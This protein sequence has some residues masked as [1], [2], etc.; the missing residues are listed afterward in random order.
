MSDRFF[1]DTNI[2][3]YVFDANAIAKAEISDR[4]IRRGIG[5]GKGLV[6]Y[7]VVQEFFN[8]AFKKF[9]V[10]MSEADAR[11]Y[12]TTTLRPMLAVF[13]SPALLLRAL[14]IREKHMIAWYDSLILAAAIEGECKT[15]YTEDFRHGWQIDG[16]KIQN[17]FR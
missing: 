12:F 3:A 6:S 9:P 1:L 10:P 2:F 7:Q 14:G 13:F 11:I 4:L 17:P 8:V 15:L 5:T 16:V